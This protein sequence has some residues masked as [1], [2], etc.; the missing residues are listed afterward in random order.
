MLDPHLDISFINTSVLSDL[1]Q[2]LVTFNPSGQLV[3]ELS[4]RWD[5]PDPRT[6]LFHIRTGVRFHDGRTLSAADV[7]ASLRRAQS[8]PLSE[9]GAFM[10]TVETIEAAGED[11]VK[12]RT[13]SPDPTLL[14]KLA[15]V[16]ILPAD[17]PET[18][19]EPIGTGPYRYVGFD[20]GVRL[21]ITAFK[22]YW[23]QQPAES[24]VEVFFVED[25]DARARMLI[26]NKADLI[27]ELPVGSV[28]QIEGD[29]DLW[30]GSYLGSAVFYL[31]IDRTNP[32]FRDLRVRQAID[33]ALNRE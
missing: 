3:A 14:N 7:V 30:V 17:S 27:G 23:G 5:N 33:H 12:L 13:R 4:E 11:V 28:D 25:A 26:E 19:K 29:A 32:L 31:A 20:P 10:A 16:P 2:K 21:R 1:Y 18:V 8:H 9:K 6:W 24:D 22:D 15:S